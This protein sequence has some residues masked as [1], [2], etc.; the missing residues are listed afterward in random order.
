MLVSYMIATKN[1]KDELLKTLESCFAQDY[2]HKEVH[3][4]DDGS[5]DG[6]SEMVRARFPETV[7]TRNDTS[8]GS[9]ASRNQIFA[10]AKGDVLI[11]FD[12]DSRFM[13]Q[14]AT[15]RVAERFARESD[16]GLLEF[17]DIGPEYPQRIQP[18]PGRLQGERHTASFGAGRY[19]IRRAVLEKAGDFVPFFWH[20]YEEPDLAIR[21][22]DA[23]FRC[24]QWNEI[25]V[26]HEFSAVNRNERRTHFFHARNELLS[27]W[28]R[29]PWSYVLPLTCWRMFSQWRYSFRRGW[30]TVEPSVWWA[31][32]RMLPLA[33][34]N[35]RPVRS[36][37][38]RRCLALNRKTISDPVA[39]W[40]LG[41]K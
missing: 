2:P 13:S 15:N 6:T 24:L 14:D 4:V 26:W 40:A 29:T 22:W 38:F 16:L 25:L 8:L 41:R 20:A 21:V 23:G 37:S 9:I 7:L 10:R 17:Q 1:R 34:R 32:L 27:N 33:L 30:W 5:T 3:V 19:A 31:A 18:G 36:E 35:R 28:M 11:G 39:A 12:D